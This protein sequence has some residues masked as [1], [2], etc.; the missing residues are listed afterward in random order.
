M[1]FV[2]LI[3]Q[4]WILMILLNNV[5][6][7]PKNVDFLSYF[8]VSGFQVVQIINLGVTHFPEVEPG[9]SKHPLGGNISTRTKKQPEI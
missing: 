5:H 8:A 9:S 7:N 3:S 4:H 2:Y 1:Y 6:I